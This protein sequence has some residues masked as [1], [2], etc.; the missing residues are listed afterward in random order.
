MVFG[1][2]NMVGSDLL[3]HI[4]LQKTL[5]FRYKVLILQKI[6][7]MAKAK[8]K[9]F[10]DWQYEEVSDEFG[11]T[12]QRTL[13]FLEH[14]KTLELPKNNAH[15]QTLEAF[16]L[17]LFDYV[18]SWNEDEY[19]FFFISPFFKLVNFLSPNY[20]AFTQRPMSVVYSQGV[21]SGIVEFMLAKG[22][23]TPKKSHFFLHEYKPEKNRDNDPLG[24]LL[25]AMIA[26]QKINLDDKPI[27]GIYVNG[28]NWF[29]VVLD[30]KNYAVSD[31]FVVTTDDIFNLF[32]VLLYLKDLMDN[33]YK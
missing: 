26:A 12:R 11:L 22:I 17:E 3:H 18:D 27:Y 7:I 24:Q 25:I 23:Q 9:S 29:I 32:A 19:K 14:L 8:V 1:G 15:Y 5:H 2:Y 6:N 21:S 30:N 13:P 28:R 31:P 16:R 10:K 20:K 33:L 4:I